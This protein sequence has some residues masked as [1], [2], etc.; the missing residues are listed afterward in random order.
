MALEIER[1]FL[2]RDVSGEGALP[3]WKRLAEDP[4]GTLYRQGY[5][6]R[7]PDRTVR[8]RIAGDKARLTVKGRTTGCT[9]SEFEYP[10]PLEDARR[11]LDELVLSPVLEKRRYRVPFAGYVW[12]VDEFDGENRGL[13]VAEVELGS[14]TETPELPDWAGKEVTGDVRY[15][16]SALSENPYARW[17]T[18]DVRASETPND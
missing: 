2:V 18:E 8:V 13:V 10:I 14:E 17:N 4:E 9:R 15:Y 7:D 1:K 11:M 16:N 12:E 5:L 6:S 3:A